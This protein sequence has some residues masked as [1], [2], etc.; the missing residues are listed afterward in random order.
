MT[1]PGD[2]TAPTRLPPEASAR[3][4]ADAYERLA[5]PALFAGW[6]ASLVDLVSPAP[7]AHVLDVGCGTGI[8]ARTVAAR[9]GP[10]GRVEAT[11]SDPAMLEVAREVSAGDAVPIGWHEGDALD[12]PFEDAAFDAV[13]CQQ[14]LQFLEDPAAALAEMRR[15]VRAG[16]CVAVG[17]WR[18]VQEG[19]ASR[20]LGAAFARHLGPGAAGEL[21]APCVLGAPA[22]LGAAVSEAGL[23]LRHAGVLVQPLRTGSAEQ[24][25]ELAA[26]ITSLTP[27]LEDLAPDARGRLIDDLDRAMGDSLAGGRLAIPVE[28]CVAVGRR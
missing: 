12:L 24:L 16:G 10:G 7:G 25:L 17:T 18:G 8:V 2:V 23:E 4:H 26:L 20:V 28:A 1:T 5:V 9:A 22:A 3:S 15:A 19:P 14:A 11:D 21:R 13:L 27:W 6:A